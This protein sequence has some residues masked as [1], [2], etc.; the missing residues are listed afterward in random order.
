MDA[1]VDSR[2]KALDARTSTLQF[3]HEGKATE[4]NS[5]AE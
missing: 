4:H 3:K 2:I 1:V 5:L